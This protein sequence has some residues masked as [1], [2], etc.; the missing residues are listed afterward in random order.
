VCHSCHHGDRKACDALCARLVHVVS[1]VQSS[2][3]RI[4]SQLTSAD[5]LGEAPT[6]TANT[7]TTTATNT[8]TTASS[9]TAMPTPPALPHAMRTHNVAL[10]DS[11]MIARLFDAYG[12]AFGWRLGFLLLYHCGNDTALALRRLKA[13][14]AWFGFCVLFVWQCLKLLRFTDGNR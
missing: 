12:L 7:T 11:S 3:S 9:V 10:P 13:M 4:I 5:M 6:K 1:V 14:G 8:D 2:F